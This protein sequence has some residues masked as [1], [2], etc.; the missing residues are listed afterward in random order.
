[1]IF[2]FIIPLLYFIL[3]NGLFVS[4]FKKAFGKCLPVT[5]MITAF[6][7]FFSQVIFHTFKI[8]LAINIIYAILFLVILAIKYKKK[9]LTDFKNNFFSKGFYAFL[10]IFIVVYIFDFNRTFT[11]WDEFSHWGVMV[12][13]MIRLDNFYSI[14]AST[15]MTHKDYPPIMQLFEMFYTTISGGYNEAYLERAMH[16]FSISLFI[17]AICEQNEKFNKFKLSV[18]SLCM[19]IGVFL[20]FCLF[21]CH[22][23]INTIYT[24]YVMAIVVAYLLFTILV[25]KD[26]LSKFSVFS[27]TIGLSFLLL[28]KQMGLPLYCMIVFMLL[29]SFCIKNRQK[30]FLRKSLLLL[31]IIIIP[32][33]FWKGW[34]MYVDEL[35]TVQQFKLSDIKI[36]K[37]RG[38]I[39]KTSG[40]YYQQV[41]ASNYIKA[42]KSTGIMT[43]TV[44]LSYFQ[45]VVLSLTLLYLVWIYGKKI[46]SKKLTGLLGIT[47][48][49]G[50]FGY[51]FVMLLLYVFSFGPREGP[52]LASFNRYMPTY[53]LICLSIVIMLFV[54]VNNNKD[55]NAKLVKYYI[56]VVAGLLLVQNPNKLPNLMPRIIKPYKN[57][58]Y[59]ETIT[60]KTLDNSNIFVLSQNGSINPFEIKY[61]INPRVTNRDYSNW[62]LKE[63]SNIQHYFEENV[64][65][66]MLTFDYLY[67]MNLDDSIDYS[68]LFENSDEILEKNQVYRII[69]N[70]GKVKLKIVK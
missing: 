41:A 57:L 69:N 61:Y 46:L 48:S 22:G 15:I 36:T 10:V 31:V 62:N 9:D 14:K 3:A 35:N 21:D 60:N 63:V 58:A 28:L 44:S 25:E 51:A 11:M 39:N 32:L 30:L 68:F 17:P 4:I 47:L 53:I 67:V 66:Y 52:A 70:N 13:E 20:V 27:L 65:D 19:M 54:F 49:L 12:K 24:D 40:E 34:G 8:G 37:L 43:S 29:L 5:M 59:V 16:L 33:L 2:S 7:Y 1:M 42:V 50:S 38:I 64:Q 45:C 55:K 6:T 18:K 26:L 56:L 23:V